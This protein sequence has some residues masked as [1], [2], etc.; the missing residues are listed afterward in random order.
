ML[1]DP[2]S[3]LDRFLMDET[4]RHLVTGK[5]KPA[6]LDPA[7][8]NDLR[9]TFHFKLSAINPLVQR[10]QPRLSAHAAQRRLTARLGPDGFRELTARLD[11]KYPS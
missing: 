5:E 6:K 1:G 2:G 4:C 7:L 3:G 11:K 10:Q 8:W 9:A